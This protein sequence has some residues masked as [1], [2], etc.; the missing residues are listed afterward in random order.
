MNGVLAF[1]LAVGAAAV[2]YR[3]RALT[4]DGAAVTT[5]IGFIVFGWGGAGAALP[6]LLFF[7]TATLWTRASARGRGADRRTDAGGRRA[8]QVV[9]NGAIPALSVV[10]F[11]I[12]GG[13]HWLA[14]FAGGLA[15]VTAD[16]WATEIGALSPRPPRLITTGAHVEPGRSGGVTWPGTIGG[17]LGALTLALGAAASFTWWPPEPLPGPPA[18]PGPGAIGMSGLLSAGSTMQLGAFVLAVFVGGVIGLLVDSLLGASLQARFHCPRCATN[19]EDA[20]HYCGTA[21][22]HI[23]GFRYCNNDMVNLLCC[24]S[25]ALS[26][27]LVYSL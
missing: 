18:E 6:L 16:T 11:A 24:L 17:V 8:V 12:W 3:W 9:A 23:G 5:I 26:S 25:G 7:G 27:F 2:A 4:I 14:A 15:A 13:N 21:A 20:I 22:E 1:I 19:T 10:G